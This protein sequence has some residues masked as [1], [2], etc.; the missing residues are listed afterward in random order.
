MQF[1]PGHWIIAA[2]AVAGV[3]I[4][5]I[6]FWIRRVVKQSKRLALEAKQEAHARR[7]HHAAIEGVLS[8][9]SAERVRIGR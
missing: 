5:I 8:E 3:A 6:C 4:C 9:I 2:F 1:D 7:I